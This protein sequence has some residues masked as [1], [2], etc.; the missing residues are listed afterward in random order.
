[1]IIVVS[2]NFLVDKWTIK[3]GAF[4]QWLN[5]QHFC[6]KYDE[7]G[8]GLNWKLSGKISFLSDQFQ[9]G[10]FPPE[11]SRLLTSRRNQTETIWTPDRSRYFYS[12]KCCEYENILCESLV[13]RIFLFLYIIPYQPKNFTAFQHNSNCLST[14]QVDKYSRRVRVSQNA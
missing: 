2:K 6:D 7:P 10:T 5:A 9:L 12:Q 14:W 8:D 11:S 13:S 3:H 1:M 4:S